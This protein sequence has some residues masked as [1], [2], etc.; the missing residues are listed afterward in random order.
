MTP[1]RIVIIGGGSYKWGP[2]IVRDLIVTQWLHGSTIVLHDIDPQALDLV[3]AVG[4]KVVEENHLPYTLEKTL[5]LEQAL[6]DADFVILTISTGG[7][8]AMRHDL[9]IPE[10]YGIYQA[11]GDTVGPG[12]VAR[13]LRNIPVVANIARKMEEICPNAWLLNYT[14]PMATLCRAITRT[15]KIKTIGLCH[16][17]ISVLKTLKAHFN[18]QDESEIQAKVGGINHLSWILELK[19]RVKDVFPELQDF[20]KQA[21]AARDKLESLDFS[22]STIDHNMVKARLFHIFGALPAA[23]DRHVADFFPYFLTEATD[24]GRQYGVMLTQIEERYQ[25]QNESKSFVYAILNGDVDMKS[26]LQP[27]NEPC[28]KVISAV[29]NGKRYIGIMN[30]PNKGQIANL[31][32]GVVVETFGIVDA[33]GAHGIA[34][35]ELPP[36]IYNV[37][38]RHVINQEMIVEAALTGNRNLALQALLND[39]LVREADSAEKMLDEMLIANKQHLPQFFA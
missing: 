1:V 19:V 6:R 38:N 7:L 3:Y 18:V 31:P 22:R 10:R 9:E 36:G 30:L 39:P 12:G 11:V 15:T 32:A 28:A 17:F 37:I 25:W 23:G 29:A 4:Q 8:E 14:N 21:L 33:N 20:A 5:R 27:S 24:K 13:A 16:E 26:F 34:I 2:L 35:G